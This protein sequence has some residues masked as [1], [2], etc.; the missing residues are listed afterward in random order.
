MKDYLIKRFFIYFHKKYHKY[1]EEWI[2]NL[3][4]DQIAYFILEKERVNIY[5]S[6]NQRNHR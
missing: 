4:E 5:E 6:I 3:T 1:V 2:R